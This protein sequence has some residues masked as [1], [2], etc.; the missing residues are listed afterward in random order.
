MYFFH[1]KKNKAMNTCALVKRVEKLNK[2]KKTK[3]KFLLSWDYLQRNYA[4]Q[5][6]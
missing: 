3:T 5:L 4:T 1:D 2:Q 6:W